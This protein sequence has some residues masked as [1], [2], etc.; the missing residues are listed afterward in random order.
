M[1]DDTGY[2]C[3]T[4]NGFYIKTEGLDHSQRVLYDA[5]TSPNAILRT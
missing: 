3:G 2:C 5:A 1:M 4:E